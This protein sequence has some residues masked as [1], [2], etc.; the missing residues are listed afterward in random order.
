MLTSAGYLKK[1]KKSFWASD[2]TSVVFILRHQRS[3][4]AF[5][6]LDND[7]PDVTQDPLQALTKEGVGSAVSTWKSVD[8][9]DNS[10]KIL[11]NN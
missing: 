7:C 4:S 8:R 5:C 1:K 9:L 3:H 10:S 11:C 6:I 2:M